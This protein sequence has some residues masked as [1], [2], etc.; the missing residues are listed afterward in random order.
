MSLQHKTTQEEFF[1][2]AQ[3]NASAALEKRG[4]M[5]RAYVSEREM[6]L[7]EENLE[8]LKEVERLN[9]EVTH[10][11][12]LAQQQTNRFKDLQTRVVDFITSFSK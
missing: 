10:A 4:H 3:E 11:Y 6:K 5:T 2:V 12:K 7:R 8:L 9:S 1:K